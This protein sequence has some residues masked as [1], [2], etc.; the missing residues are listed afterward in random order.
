MSKSGSGGAN[1]PSLVLTAE[2]PTLGEKGFSGPET[3]D[4]DP[5][6]S[7]DEQNWNKQ[8]RRVFQRSVT[9]LKY[10]DAR[11]YGVLWLT[12]TSCPESKPSSELAYSHQRLRQR[13]ERADLA[14]CDGKHCPHHHERRTVA[15]EAFHVA[16]R[17]LGPHLQLARLQRHLRTVQSRP[18]F[19]QP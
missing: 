6:D 19:G 4:S 2:N 7:D 10:W 11:N 14:M 3:D 16:R 17:R 9:M 15:A 13:V 5:E 18:L 1:G 8:Q 12:F